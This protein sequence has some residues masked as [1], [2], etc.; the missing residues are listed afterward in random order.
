MA[1]KLE[2]GGGGWP[3]TEVACS[4][5]V[6]NKVGYA[7][8]YDFPSLKWLGRIKLGIKLGYS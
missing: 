4:N 3:I 7:S 1:I 5:Q 6:E 8:G 2:I